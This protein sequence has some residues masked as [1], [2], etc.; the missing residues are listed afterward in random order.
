MLLKRWL[1]ITASRRVARSLA[2]VLQQQLHIRNRI[3]GTGWSSSQP[4]TSSFLSLSFAIAHFDHRSIVR[5]S[6]AVFGAGNC[7]CAVVAL[8]SSNSSSSKTAWKSKSKF[9]ELE[10]M[11]I[12]RQYTYQHHR[13][14]RRHRLTISTISC[15]ADLL[16][17]T[18]VAR[19]WMFHIFFCK[20]DEGRETRKLV[21]DIRPRRAVHKIEC[22]PPRECVYLTK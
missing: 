17:R 6:L 7:H 22:I 21:S 11:K 16:C 13:D 1:Q 10:I 9:N 18:V 12:I 20:A 5:S 15:F 4:S 3:I 8:L 14:S 19:C 2:T